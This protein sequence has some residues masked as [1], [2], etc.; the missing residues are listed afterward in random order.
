M[1]NSA[2]IRVGISSCLLGEPVRYDGGHKRDPYLVETLGA[3]VEYVPVCPEYEAGLG[4]PREAMRLAGDPAAPR[5]VTQKTGID[6]TSRMESWIAGRLR[7]LATEDL[8]GFIF[9]SGSPSSGM[10]RVKVYDEK[11]NS[12]KS[13]SGLFARAFMERFP[14]VPAEDEGRLHDIGI[15]ENFIVRV[16][17]RYRWKEQV[18]ADRRPAS[19]IRFHARHKYLL[20]AHSP[21]VQKELGR[22]VAGVKGMKPADFLAQ[23]ES[24]FIRALASLATPKKNAN[25]LMH[26]A[27]YFRDRIGPDEKKELLDVIE[28]Y[29]MEL[30]PLIV[31]V[32][33][34]K[35]YVRKYGEEYL[36]DQYYLDPHPLELKLRNHA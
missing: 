25:V 20:M 6:L 29:R 12:R 8:C 13:G 11:G 19:I 36:S 30:V 7:G 26:L 35:H 24:L 17:A 2:K 15:R 23:Y 10:E 27:G 28:Q 4:V 1:A 5:L 34:I 31:P 9:K 22:L 21:S 14:L 32:T 3:F 33:I 16:F 18:A